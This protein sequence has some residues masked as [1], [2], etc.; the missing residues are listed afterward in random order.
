MAC[1]ARFS[2]RK[3]TSPISTLSSDPRPALA[4]RLG[5][6][7]ATALALGALLTLAG[8]GVIG[9]PIAHIFHVPCPGCGATR[10]GWALFAL[11][12]PGVLR[13]N[14]V[15]LLNGAIMAALWVRAVMLIARDGDIRAI[16]DDALG[17]GLILAYC[18]GWLIGIV[19]WALRFFG[20]FGGPC[21]V[22]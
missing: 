3:L 9:C 16:Y 21:P 20:L 6:A 7:I 15:A 12:L 11:D 5:R 17:R 19:Y 18:A 2:G 22:G 14:A 10:S 1:A 8:A 4:R 13:W